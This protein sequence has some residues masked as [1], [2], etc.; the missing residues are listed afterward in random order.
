M[1]KTTNGEVTYLLSV[2]IDKRCNPVHT[3][4][5][6][7]IW[8]PCIKSKITSNGSCILMRLVSLFHLYQE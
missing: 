3:P 8:S 7:Y 5:N 1:S 2:Y 4:C 6:N